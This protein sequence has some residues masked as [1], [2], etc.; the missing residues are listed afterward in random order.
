M[1]LRG[2]VREWFVAI[3]SVMLLTLGACGAPEPRDGEALPWSELQEHGWPRGAVAVVGLDSYFDAANPSGFLAILFRNGGVRYLTIGPGGGLPSNVAGTTCFA[4]QDVTYRVDG[5]SGQ[6]WR[7]DGLQRAIDWL[8][9]VDGQ[10]VVVTNEGMLSNGYEMNV[11]F[12]GPGEQ[13][14]CVV[15]RFPGPVATYGS[16]IYLADQDR[17]TIKAHTC[18]LETGQ[19]LS[20]GFT[21][22]AWQGNRDDYPKV[23][24]WSTEERPYHSYRGRLWGLETVR[25][26]EWS[27]AEHEFRPGKRAMM[28]LA[29]INPDADTYR[30][31]LLGYSPNGWFEP[32]ADSYQA[33]LGLESGRRGGYFWRGGIY[34]FD[35][36]NRLVRIDL[37][38][39]RYRILGRSSQLAREGVGFAVG[40]YGDHLTVLAVG[41]SGRTVLE[42]YDLS[43]GGVRNTITVND[44][45]REFV[46]SNELLFTGLAPLR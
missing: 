8:G 32:A 24:S 41:Q 5:E 27:G 34:T 36:Q 25:A 1:T 29:E 19:S 13:S 46:N 11:H 20:T 35:T 10:C 42:E 26:K 33:S 44:S 2:A 4:S 3:A 9:Q 14:K 21:R 16:R 30:S 7:R 37:D 15:N 12:G 22:R 23:A 38:T 28:R 31:H 6:R 45:L 43:N 17:R 40:G 39:A 18:D